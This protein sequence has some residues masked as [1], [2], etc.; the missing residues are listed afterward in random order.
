MT[1]RDLNSDD[2]FT[3]ERHG[4]ITVITANPALEAP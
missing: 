2:A 4:D 1:S 3:L